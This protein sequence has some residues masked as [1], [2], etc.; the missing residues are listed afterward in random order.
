[1]DRKGVHKSCLAFDGVKLEH[2]WG[3]DHDAYKIGGKMFALVG[4]MGGLSFKVSHIAFE[5]LTESGRAR[6]APYLARAKWVH[7][8]NIGDWPDDQLA[9]YLKEAYNIVAGGLPKSIRAELGLQ[10]LSK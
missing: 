8:D 3:D 6:P 5:I 1:M 9:A 10:V 2:P 4:A 7:L